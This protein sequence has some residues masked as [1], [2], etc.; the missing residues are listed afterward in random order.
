MS[1]RLIWIEIGIH[2]NPSFYYKSLQL[3]RANLFAT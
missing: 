3:L 2:L 1:E